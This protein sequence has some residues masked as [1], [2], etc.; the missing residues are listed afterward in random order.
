M[1]SDCQV[2]VVDA[3]RFAPIREEAL[4]H[5]EAV[6]AGLVCFLEQAGGQDALYEMRE[7]MCTLKETAIH[8]EWEAVSFLAYHTESLLTAL[9]RGQIDADSETLQLLHKSIEGI[10]L[11]VIDPCDTDLV[12]DLLGR[13]PDSLG[14]SDSCEKTT[15]KSVHADEIAE[16]VS[17]EL[18]EVFREESNEILDVIEG[19]LSK[20]QRE[21]HDAEALQEIR[22]ATHILRGAAGAVQM[23]PVVQLTQYM[24][25][26]LE[27]MFANGLAATPEVLE[28]L[29]ESR[30]GLC[31]SIGKTT[32]ES[33]QSLEPLLSL[34]ASLL[35]DHQ[36]DPPSTAASADV[37]RD[38]TWG[39]EDVDEPICTELFAV[40]CEEVED[41]F[42]VIYGSLGQLE[43][44]PNDR[45][46]LQE[47]RRTAHT[48][49]GAAGAVG[50][51]PVTQLAHRMEDVLDGV[52]EG[53]VT[54]TQ[55]TVQVL[56]RG[57]DC[58]QELAMQS[59]DTVA[60]AEVIDDLLSDFASLVQGKIQTEGTSAPNNAAAQVA[61]CESPEKAEGTIGVPASVPSRATSE[62]NTRRSSR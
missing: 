44:N 41:I 51:R 12:D 18:F 49:K 1:A 5:L 57:T 29:T 13:F 2:G 34:Y 30:N 60:N 23:H 6:A 10:A 58:L 33:Q 35:Q 19:S 36:P 21:P 40:F 24:E 20:L 55:D 28:L 32:E 27:Q 26:L 42:R 22:R 4:D 3:E 50:L 15:A 48:L 53:G 56:Y 8:V 59:G 39:N 14:D 9:H 17:R 25:D 54:V 38:S 46:A 47:I 43:E 52:Y 62:S 16:V 7:R 61:V 37:S 11:V 31:Q 45:D